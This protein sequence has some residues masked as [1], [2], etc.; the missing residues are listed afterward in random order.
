MVKVAMV[1]AEQ[2][3]ESLKEGVSLSSPLGTT[4]RLCTLS[5]KIVNYS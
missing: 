2:R 4:V 5:G 3:M 1:L